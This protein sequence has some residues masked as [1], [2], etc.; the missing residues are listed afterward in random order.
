MI[1]YGSI[2]EK[3]MKY[4]NVPEKI[5]EYGSVPEYGSVSFDQ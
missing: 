4:G 1:K 2:P 3:I 5:V